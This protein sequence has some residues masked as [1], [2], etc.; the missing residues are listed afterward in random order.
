MPLDRPLRKK[1]L[2]RFLSLRKG[3]EGDRLQPRLTDSNR[4]LDGCLQSTIKKASIVKTKRCIARTVVFVDL[5]RTTNSIKVGEYDALP[6]MRF[7]FL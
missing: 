1:A 7:Y 6:E 3:G 4:T 2:D 5:T